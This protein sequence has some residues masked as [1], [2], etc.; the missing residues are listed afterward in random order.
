MS[1]HRTSRL[2]IVLQLERRR[3]RRI[4]QQMRWQRVIWLEGGRGG[5]GERLCKCVSNVT[6]WLTRKMSTAS[7]HDCKEALPVACSDSRY[8]I[9][10][11][12][13]TFLSSL[14]LYGCA[15]MW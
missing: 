14:V 1:R 9:A 3:M 2:L 10:S 5:V 12:E 8:T 6:P 11:G 7:K 13:T 4:S 15:E